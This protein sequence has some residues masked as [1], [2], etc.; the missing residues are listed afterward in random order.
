MLTPTFISEL[1]INEILQWINTQNSNLELST[2][3]NSFY[4]KLNF[5]NNYPKCL[6]EI[7]KRCQNITNGIYQE[8]IFKDFIHEIKNGG[9]VSE[10]TDPTI[11]GCKHL[12][13]NILLQKPEKGGKLIIE[14]KFI[15]WDVGDMF[16]VDTALVHGVSKIEGKI[17]YKSIVFG[18]L[19]KE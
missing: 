12:R 5:L 11:E 3:F 7:R 6:N 17:N 9:F 16:V 14:K 13:C 8:P 10:H 4:S 15:D 18:F 19:C 1:Q 2:G